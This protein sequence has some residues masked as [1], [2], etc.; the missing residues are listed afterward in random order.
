MTLLKAQFV[1][2]FMAL[3]QEGVAYG[4]HERNGGNLSYRVPAELVVP[5]EKAL[6]TKADFIP[7]GTDVPS[8]KG[9]YF[10]VT[11]SG[12][13]LRNISLSPE[14][15]IALVKLNDTGTHYQIL[16]GL[17]YGGKPTSEFP[18][19][20][21]CHAIKKAQDPAYRVIYHAHPVNITALSGMLPA[22]D[23]IMTK[24][25]WGTMTECPVIY[26]QGLGVV[27]WMVPGGREIAVATA[28]KMRTFHYDAVIWALHGIFC[29]GKTFDDA[30]SLMHVI[31]KS[32]AIF[33]LQAAMG[34][35]V[36]AIPE[37]GYKRLAKEFNITL[38]ESSL[39]AVVPPIKR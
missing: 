9:E 13:F 5:F 16:W 7:I 6:N 33:N 39:K 35:P 23:D 19:H 10:L 28:D 31:E 1:Q 22:D 24:A 29:A 37:E 14:E 30:I 2:D 26:P 21:E 12:K 36:N 32:A 27:P 18:T 25:T 8:L 38:K 11:G 15:N 17:P 3:A 34:T 4:W 20:L